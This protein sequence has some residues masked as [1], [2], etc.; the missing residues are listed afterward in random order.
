MKRRKCLTRKARAVRRLAGLGVMLFFSWQ[1]LHM[2]YVL[3]I[4]ALRQQEQAIGAGTTEVVSRFWEP[5][6]LYGGPFSLV[7]ITANQHIVLFKR[8]SFSVHAG[9]EGSQAPVI[10][11]CSGEQPFFS[12]CGVVQLEADE[13]EDPQCRYYFFG[14]VDDSSIQRIEAVITYAHATDLPAAQMMLQTDREEWTMLGDIAFFS[15]RSEP[16]VWLGDREMTLTTAAYDAAGKLV[17]CQ[18]SA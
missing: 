1:V 3:P 6:T 8:V 12:G 18:E 13:G 15:L 16:G 2:G 14:R 9:W 7:Y 17:A 10:L 4:Q 11:D 5:E